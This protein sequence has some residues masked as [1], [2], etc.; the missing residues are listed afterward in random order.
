MFYTWG[1]PCNGSTRV[2]NTKRQRTT[3]QQ[4]D[5]NIQRKQSLVKRKTGSLASKSVQIQT[6]TG[7]PFQCQVHNDADNELE[8]AGELL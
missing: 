1:T 7:F 2:T 4:V 3:E 6:G 8:S 5:T